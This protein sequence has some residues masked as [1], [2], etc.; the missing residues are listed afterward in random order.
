LSSCEL[1]PL[2]P[3]EKEFDFNAKVEI[4]NDDSVSNNE[5]YIWRFY[6]YCTGEEIKKY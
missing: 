6:N 2:P 3:L 1:S 4:S 5:Q